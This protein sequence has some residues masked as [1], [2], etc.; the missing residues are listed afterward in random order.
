M[1]WEQES[2]REIRIKQ[3]LDEL[4]GEGWELICVSEHEKSKRTFYLKR[5]LVDS[6]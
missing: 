5:V 3:Q 4:G 6:L 1:K 2:E